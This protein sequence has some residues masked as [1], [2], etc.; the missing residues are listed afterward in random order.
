MNYASHQNEQVKHR[1]M[2][3]MQILRK[4]RLLYNWFDGYN[5]SD[6]RRNG[7]YWFLSHYLKDGMTLFDVGAN[8]GDYTAYV[9]SLDSPVDIH[10]FEP[11]Q[12]TFAQLQSRHGQNPQVRLNNFG[13]SN[14]EG[15]AHMKIYG[16]TYGINSL[17]ERRSSVASQPAYAHYVEQSV[18][19]RTLDQYVTEQNISRIDMLKIDVE[20]HELRVLEGATE[21][22]A[23]SKITAI[24]FEYGSS[25]VDARSSLKAIYDLVTT[26]GFKLYRLWNYG[27]WN[28]PSFDPVWGLENYRHSNWI[29][30]RQLDRLMNS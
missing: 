12:E 26:Y 25:F 3:D 4:I 21:S 23:A 15:T 30:I 17:Y 1:S 6:P 29:A 27:K 11:V 10:C 18:V 22:L 14:V 16:E 7:E 2:V 24:Q 8:I 19:L 20:G 28:I 13:L 5:F 9:L